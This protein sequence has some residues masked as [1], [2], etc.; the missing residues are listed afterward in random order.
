MKADDD[1]DALILPVPPA[2]FSLVVGPAMRA[3]S[4]AGIERAIRHMGLRPEPVGPVDAV[5]AP[6]VFRL[7]FGSLS[8]IAGPAA[9]ATLDQA[10]PADPMT[11][12]LAASLPRDWRDRGHCWTF[13][14]E[15]GGG[16]KVTTGSP[17]GGRD[18]FKAMALLIDLFDASHLFWSPARLW[19]DAP[20]FRASVAEMLS[21]GMPPVLHLVAFRRHDGEEGEIIGTRGL[22][23]FAGQEL[24]APM[25]PGWTV[26]EMVRR[27]A[28]LA[29]DMMLHGRLSDNRDL[30]GLAPGEVIRLSVA[31]GDRRAVRVEFG[32]EH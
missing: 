18:F 29:L 21:S 7:R 10:D 6:P 32:R 13:V 5:L 25:P 23:L 11:S 17:A 22:M 16:R 14:P 12:L 8:L 3:A 26:A 20:Q 24:E 4:P 19:S 28:R 1:S 31:G 30:R 9:D 2:P 15:E 27:L